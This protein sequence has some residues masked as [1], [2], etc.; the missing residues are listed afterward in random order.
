MAKRQFQ[1]NEQEQ[2]AF[3]EAEQET[4]DAYELKRLQAVRLYG[5]GVP[6]AEIRRLVHCGERTI[7]HWSQRYQQGG[8]EGLKSQWQGE[9]ALKLSREQRSDQ[10]TQPR[11]ETGSWVK[12]RCSYSPGNDTP[13][14]GSERIGVCI[15]R[16]CEIWRE[17][18]PRTGFWNL[19][20]GLLCKE[21]G[22][23]PE[24]SKREWC[25]LRFRTD[26]GV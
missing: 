15:R 10:A 4:R 14:D 26:G 5:S 20:E 12:P 3:Q 21:G 9:N 22:P 6:T 1:L 23:T 7:R 25:V 16:R 11:T 2:G 24:G 18:S 17:W 19:G 13:P 8:L